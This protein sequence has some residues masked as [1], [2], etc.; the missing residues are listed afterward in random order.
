MLRVTRAA[1][2]ADEFIAAEHGDVSWLDK[3]ESDS[4]T[5]I[6][7]LFSSIDYCREPIVYP[8]PWI[9]YEDKPS[10]IIFEWGAAVVA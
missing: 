1:M 10:V 3:V 2:S 5:P 7:V 4:S 9:A 8:A 6:S